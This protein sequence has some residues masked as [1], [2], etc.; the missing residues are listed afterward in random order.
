LCV[1]V[2]RRVVVVPH[3]DDDSKERGDGGH[4]G[5]LCGAKSMLASVIQLILA[6]N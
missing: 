1:N 2:H 4:G 5:V 6:A 3:T